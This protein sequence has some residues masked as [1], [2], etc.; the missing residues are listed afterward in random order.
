MQ[1]TFFYLLSAITAATASPL[2]Q[3][4]TAQRD[5][6]S[7][8]NN[9]VNKVSIALNGDSHIARN[10]AAQA[11]NIVASTIPVLGSP[12]SLP[13]IPANVILDGAIGNTALWQEALAFDTKANGGAMN[14]NFYR[15]LAYLQKCENSSHTFLS[16]ALSSSSWIGRGL[17][18]LNT[19]PT[20]FSQP[21][22]AD[23]AVSLGKI[24]CFR[25]I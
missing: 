25:D 4:P 18:Y 17:Q 22:A 10:A 21:Q 14:Q 20:Q 5:L 8:Y 23:P 16:N 6:T 2:H 19:Y 1:A 7:T 15:L 3:A 13:S 24:P 9:A 11:S 12:D